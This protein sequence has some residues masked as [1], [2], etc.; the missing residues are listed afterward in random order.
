VRLVDSLLPAEA[1]LVNGYGPTE[2]TTFTCCHAVSRPVPAAWDSIPIGRPIAN[3]RVYVLDEAGRPLGVGDPGELYIGGD[4]LALGY[5]NDPELTASRFVVNPLPGLSDVR[6]YRSGDR[7]SWRSDGTL[8]FLGRL[9]EQVKIRGHRVEPAEVERALQVHARVARAVVAVHTHSAGEKRL[10][11][12]YTVRTASGD[13]D[14]VA[15]E[16][17][18]EPTAADLRAH[19][20][21]LLPEVMQPAALVRLATLPLNANGKVDRAALPLPDALL[22]ER[23]AAE[24]GL[25]TADQRAVAGIWAEA[26]R[27]TD[28]GAHDH[29]FFDL[30]GNSLLAAQVI[31]RVNR[32][33]GVKL[34]M[35]D[36]LTTPT[37][38]SLS[39]KVAARRKST[40]ADVPYLEVIRRGRGHD[41]VVCVGFSNVLP[42]L[43]AALAAEVPL[44]WLKLDGLHAPP[45]AVRSVSEIASGYADELSAAGVRRV[46]LVGHSYCGLI[47]FELTRRLRRAGMTVHAML[48]EPSLPEMFAR[49]HQGMPE[50]PRLAAPA[51][52]EATIRKLPWLRRLLPTTTTPR[53]DGAWLAERLKR[54]AQKSL[55]RPYLKL[56]VRLG[57]ELPPR[58]REWW[59]YGSQ[60]MRRIKQFEILRS[61]GPFWLAGQWAYLAT[62]ADCWQTHIDGDM[63]V[64]PLPEA[65]CHA[66]ILELPAAAAWLAVVRAWAEGTEWANDPSIDRDAA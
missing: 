24:L 55:L 44:W 63:P 26:L 10:V 25:R 18:N 46:T 15:T 28:I 9:D 56:T 65:R 7:V 60:I 12:Y 51:L 35:Q 2:G 32:R 53:S 6:L 58:H 29:F 22:A 38:V 61:P 30:A 34:S 36:L 39:A 52:P 5:L 50:D 4:G 1:R 42:V 21:G 33:F 31:D 48:L 37:V 62:Y 11:A 43:Q 20:R 14:P 45:Y 47:A 17:E 13:A 8:E 23:P 57:R 27:C 66:E 40:Q 3:T 19:L 16:S 64:C 41:P 49:G 54:R 59:Y